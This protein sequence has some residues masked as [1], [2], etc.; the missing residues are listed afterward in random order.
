MK[1]ISL[2]LV[3]VCLVTVASA[4]SLRSEIKSLNGMVQKAMLSKDMKSLGKKM[5]SGVTSDFKYMERGQAMNFDTMVKMMDQG[6][7]S[8]AKV[9][10]AKS[11]ILTLK[12]TGKS[13]AGTTRHTV[14]GMIMGPDKKQH[15]MLMVGV[16]SDTYKKVGGKWKMSSMSWKDEKTTMDGKPFDPSKMG[17]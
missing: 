16:S 12:E 5:K 2:P 8:F 10:Q 14:S 6:M 3:L 4:D 17:G 13:A 11:E 9:T 7:A 1:A 15:T